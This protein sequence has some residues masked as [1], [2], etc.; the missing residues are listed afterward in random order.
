MW[1]IE[2][3]L[4]PFGPW[5]VVKEAW[6]TNLECKDPMYP[7]SIEQCIKQYLDNI[8]YV[9]WASAEFRFREIKTGKILPTDLI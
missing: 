3:Q 4:R 8:P 9:K 6:F 7:R 1:V 5:K 2:F